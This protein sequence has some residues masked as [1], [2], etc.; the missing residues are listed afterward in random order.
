MPDMRAKMAA[1]GRSFSNCII[2]IE[3][4]K[5]ISI[6]LSQQLIQSSN[7]MAWTQRSQC[8]RALASA[9][10]AGMYFRWITQRVPI[11]GTT[12]ASDRVVQRFHGRKW[13]RSSKISI[14]IHLHVLHHKRRHSAQSILKL[15]KIHSSS[16]SSYLKHCFMAYR[17]HSLHIS[18]GCCWMNIVHGWSKSRTWSNSQLSASS[19]IIYSSQICSWLIEKLERLM[20]SPFQRA[21]E[22]R[23]NDQRKLARLWSTFQLKVYM[24]VI[25]ALPLP[26]CVKK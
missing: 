14:C 8:I 24:W 20:T 13:S 3:M 22:R 16:I 7:I 10:T 26:S 11:H 6:V 5:T 17:A 18:N 23:L 9:R 19:S 1:W 2:L 25:Q 15:R 21:S 12:N 4:Q